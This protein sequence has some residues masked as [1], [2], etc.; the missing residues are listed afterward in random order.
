MDSKN[1]KRA[2]PMVS[3]LLVFLLVS[4]DTETTKQYPFVYQGQTMGTSFTV[5]AS[6]VPENVDQQALKQQI[7]SL[8]H[9][10]NSSMSTYIET[11]EIS[12]F[13]KS[14]STEW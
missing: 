13:N 11:S 9:E 5:K 1:N 7:K 12:L 2:V 3:L 10:I 6:V 8:L 4:C 14:S